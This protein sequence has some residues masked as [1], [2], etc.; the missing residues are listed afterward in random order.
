[1]ILNKHK[2]LFQGIGKLD[3]EIH[4]TVKPNVLPYVVPVHRVAHSL[5]EPLKKELDRSVQEGIIVLLGID[6]PGEWCLQTI[7]KNRLC[8]DPT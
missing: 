5:Q 3:G 7:G 8:F 4:I 6:K 2:E 1:M